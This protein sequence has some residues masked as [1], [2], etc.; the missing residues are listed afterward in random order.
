MQEKSH[1]KEEE[2]IYLLESSILSGD[3]LFKR[4][5]SRRTVPSR[6]SQKRNGRRGRGVGWASCQAVAGNGAC[7]LTGDACFPADWQ[8]GLIKAS[9]RV[10]GPEDA[11]KVD[12][13]STKNAKD[14]GQARV[15]HCWLWNTP[16]RAGEEA[17]G[18]YRNMSER[19]LLIALPFA[20]REY[21]LTSSSSADTKSKTTKERQEKSARASKKNLHPGRGPGSLRGR[22]RALTTGADARS[23]T[24]RKTIPP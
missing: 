18:S 23:S 19:N 20:R 2:S 16:R 4:W 22:G 1:T 15:C 5:T 13:R 14:C 6:L 17:L 24:S 9:L 3:F 21:Y 10:G 11:E 7:R 12:S 8:H